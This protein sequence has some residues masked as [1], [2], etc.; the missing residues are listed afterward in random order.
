MVDVFVQDEFVRKPSNDQTND[1]IKSYNL[2]LEIIKVFNHD[3][4][5]GG[6]FSTVEEAKNKNPDDPEAPLFSILYKLSSSSDPFH[7]Q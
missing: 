7:F 4:G 2:I 3:S 1:H 6:L 5:A